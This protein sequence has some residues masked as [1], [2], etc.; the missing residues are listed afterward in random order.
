MIRAETPTTAGLRHIVANL[1]SRD[2]PRSYWFQPGPFVA[3]QQQRAPGSC[4]RQLIPLLIPPGNPGGYNAAETNWRAVVA[5]NILT[6]RQ[7]ETATLPEGAKERFLNDGDGL[8]L[9][10]RPAGRV[11]VFK[12]TSP[13]LHERRKQFFGAY[14][15]VSLAM[16]RQRADES[17]QLLA[18][19]KDP[20]EQAEQAAALVKLADAPRTLQDLFERWQAE[21]LKNEHSDKGKYV[22]GMMERYVLPHIGGLLIAEIR[23]RHIVPV[24][25]KV[26]ATGKLRTT[27][28]VFSNLKQMLLYAVQCDWLPGDPMAALKKGTFAGKRPPRNRALTDDEVRELVTK[29]AASDLPEPIECAIWIMLATLARVEELSLAR[30]REL[31]YDRKTWLVPA[32][33]QKQTNRDVPAED[34]LVNL[35]PFAEAWF[36]R[37]EQVHL[38]AAKARW[39]RLP[40]DKRPAAPPEVEIDWLFPA[41]KRPGPI[42]NK[43][44]THA[45]DDRQRPDGIARKGRT[46]QV[47][48]LKLGGGKWTP[49]DLRRTGASVMRRLRTHRDVVHRCQ[50]HVEPDKMTATYQVDE[51]REEMR[52][53][54]LKLGAHIAALAASVPQA[55][56][57]VA[58]DL[59]DEDD[60]SRDD[61]TDDDEEED[62]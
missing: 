13:T 28:V 61:D 53:G 9:R 15:T 36:R 35:S 47:D 59:A 4:Q 39:E 30:R 54:W 62:I 18:E 22:T 24:L 38:D 41:A 50:N 6:S 56:A 42:N 1:V 10:L 60:D 12:F 29:I 40:E 11:W 34:H 17:R 44:I 20:L 37:L 46:K 14:P 27:E 58:G 3:Q 52:E 48:A 21:W 55:P 26:K 32:Q 2:F 23:G 19:G 7:V 33:N 16:A 51:L 57:R 8:N 49:H 5:R 25:Q 45:V 31:D 43:T